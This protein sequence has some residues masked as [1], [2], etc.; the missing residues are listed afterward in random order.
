M[1]DGKPDMHKLVLGVIALALV[2]GLL[3]AVPIQAHDA[4]KRCHAPRRLKY[5]NI[6]RLKAHGS[7]SCVRARRVAS[8]WDERCF[9]RGDPKCYPGPVKIRVKP[10][11]ECR[12]EYV[13]CCEGHGTAAKVRCTTRG[14]RIVHFKGFS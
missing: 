5:Q 3:T 2:V 4:P 10:G 7:V 6:G 14:R 8:R 1:R 13:P 11:Y 9:Y 12:Q